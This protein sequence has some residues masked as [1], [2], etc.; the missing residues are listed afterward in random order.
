MAPE[1]LLDPK[2]ATEASD[3]FS[4]GAIAYP[5]LRRAAPGRQPGRGGPGAGGAQRAEGLRRARRGRAR[6]GGADPLEH[7]PRRRPPHR[8]GEPTSSKLLD[9][10]EDELTGPGRTRRSTRRGPGA[11]TRSRAAS[12]SSGSSARARPASRCWRAAT[13]RSSSSRSPATPD[14]DARLATRRPRPSE[15]PQR[16]HRRPARGREIG[17]RAVLVLDK[18]GD[19][20]LAERLRKEGRLGLELLQRFG[21]DLL[22]AVCLA[23]AH[24]VAHRDIK[25]DNIGVRSRQ[26]SGCNWSCSTSR[27]RAPGRSNVQ[28]GTHRLPRPVPVEA[29]ARRG[30]TCRPSGMRRR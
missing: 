23:G 27:C 19:E 8:V 28:V 30:G 26:G 10:V 12:S 3:V 13:A 20:T 6:A 14:D 1:A 16:V 7:P 29:Q 11:A 5:P 4:L 15:A 9:E 22:Q 24:G 18:A 2:A 17:G 21:D 25:P